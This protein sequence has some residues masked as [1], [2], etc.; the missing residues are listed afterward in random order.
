MNAK[1]GATTSDDFF[2][3]ILLMYSSP[4]EYLLTKLFPIF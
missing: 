1:K 3:I 4:D 2:T